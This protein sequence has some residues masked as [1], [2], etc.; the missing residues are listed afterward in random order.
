ML[1]RLLTKTA[2]IF[3]LF[4]MVAAAETAVLE[5]SHLPLQEAESIIKSQ[6]SPSGSV[7]SMASRSMVII[8]DH[9]ANIEQAKALLKRLDVAAKQYSANLELTSLNDEQ[10]RSIRTEARLPG[11]WIIVSLTNNRSHASSRRQY[12][13]Y[14]TSGREGTIESGTIQPYQ[15][16]T[17]QWLAGYGVISSSSVELVPITSGFYATVRPAGNN[18]VTVRIVPWMR[19]LR[20]NTGVQGNSEVLIDLGSA[21]APQQAP[22]NNAA[23]RLNATPTARQNEPIEMIG[24]ATEVTIP[25]GETI[26]IAASDQEA[27]LLGSALLSGSSSI[28]KNS[29]VIRLK[30]DQH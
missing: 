1:K 23:L 5:I 24:A 9:A 29:F 11:G 22:G 25:V 10:S 19:N 4:P 7:T 26:A 21:N 2:L 14:L 20:G 17:R 8:N 27:A 16:A 3:L 15:Q 6:L 13:L 30:V 28:G 12:N 18:M